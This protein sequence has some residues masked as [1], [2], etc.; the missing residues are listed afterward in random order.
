M[1]KTLPSGIEISL[2]PPT[3]DDVPLM[4]EIGCDPVACEMAGV[5]PR[6]REAFVARWK[7]IFAD[8]AINT[9]V[10]E[11]IAPV[12][13]AAEFAGSISVFQAPGESRDSLGYWIARPYW[14]RGIAS[15]ALAMFLTQE[16]RRPLHATASM[17]NLASHRVLIKN[18]FYL[19]KQ[20]SGEETDR[21]LAREVGEFVLE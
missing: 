13:D 7:E 19:V 17:Q 14:G 3:W 5:K 4:F 16:R 10:I 2:R 6:T 12:T 21:Y 18:G 9:R 8:P 1:R 20:Y 11:V 15:H